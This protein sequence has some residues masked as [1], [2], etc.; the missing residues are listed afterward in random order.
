MFRGS[1][2]VCSRKT[3]KGNTKRSLCLEDQ[4]LC[5]E[6]RLEKGTLRG[7][8]KSQLSLFTRDRS[9]NRGN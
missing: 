9:V 4:L 8:L 3:R 5:V 2:V 7:V 6:G 1:A